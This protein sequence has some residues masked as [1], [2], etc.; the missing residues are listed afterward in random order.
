MA[1]IRQ[2]PDHLCVIR[3]TFFDAADQQSRLFVLFLLTPGQGRQRPLDMLGHHGRSLRQR[4]LQGG[5]DLAA[6]RSVAKGHRQ[7]ATPALIAD[8]AD[9]AAFRVLEKFGLALAPQH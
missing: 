5:Q 7:V 3:Q 4:L 1:A 2:V 8:A 9:G 6:G